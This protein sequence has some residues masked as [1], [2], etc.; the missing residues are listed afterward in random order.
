MNG[1]RKEELWKLL[2]AYNLVFKGD[3]N[4][5]SSNEVI[6]ICA[7]IASLATEGLLEYRQDAIDELH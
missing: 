3:P 6:D 7:H 1:Q 2:H 4:V 5:S